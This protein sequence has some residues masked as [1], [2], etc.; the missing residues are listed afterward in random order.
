MDP[1]I[2]TVVTE[3]GARLAV[4]DGHIEV[5]VRVEGKKLITRK[6]NI[7]EHLLVE[8]V[9]VGDKWELVIGIEEPKCE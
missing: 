7:D 4:A 6:A 5:L 1:I 9:Q 2:F 3:S 8:R